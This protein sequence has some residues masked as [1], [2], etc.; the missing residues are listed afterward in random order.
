MPV[1][2]IHVLDG[3]YNEARLGKVSQAVQNALI[4]ALDIPAGRFLSD[5]SRSAA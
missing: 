2:K 1:A 3:R 4:S 5:N